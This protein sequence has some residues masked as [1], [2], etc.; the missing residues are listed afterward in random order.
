MQYLAEQK[1]EIQVT[2]SKKSAAKNDLSLKQQ[3]S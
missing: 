3:E 2:G 1:K